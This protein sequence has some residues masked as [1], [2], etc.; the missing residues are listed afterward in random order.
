MKQQT[1]ASEDPAPQ[2]ARIRDAERT[3]AALLAAATREFADRGYGSARI[4][5]IVKRAGVSKQVLYYYFGSK[6][7]LYVAVLEEAYAGLRA[8]EARLELAGRDPVEGIRE[9][10]LS[11]WRYHTRHREL[12]SLVNTE[13]LHRAKHLKRSA[14]IAGLNSPLIA[15]LTDLIARG[16]AAGRFRAD[17]DAVDTY[18]TIAAMT[19]YYL[20]NH[21]TLQANFQRDLMDPARLDLWGR[22]IVD[23]A[24][25]ALEPR[26]GDVG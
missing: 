10:A 23:V 3:K 9:L 13:N 19:F 6:E 21:W 22:H 1:V 17:A 15:E 11:L 18:I 7:A 8:E 25:R 4:D 5:Q 24:L 14:R 12:I 2:K 26:D 16:K 20:S